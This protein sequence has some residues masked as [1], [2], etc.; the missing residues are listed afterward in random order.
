[1]KPG[2]RRRVDLRGF[3]WQL[4]AL[5]RNL[6]HAVDL[7]RAALAA[8]QRRAETLETTLQSLETQKAEQLQG[9]VASAGQRIDPAAQGRLLRFLAQAEARRVAR[10]LEL[11]RLRDHVA[12]ARQEC[13]AADR[14]L[15]CLRRLR[16]SAE[17]VHATAQ[18][19][20]EA[21]EADLAWLTHASRARRTP[22]ST[23]EGSA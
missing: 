14:E 23:R 6:E 4:A 12:A 13:T 22:A 5:E 21:K 11:A 7:A 19:R 10:Q 16:E 17:A 1:M 18:L 2:I 8:A 15:A 9:A 20:R 3:P